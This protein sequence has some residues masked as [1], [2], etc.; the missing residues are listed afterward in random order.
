MHSETCQF[1]LDT[2]KEYQKQKNNDMRFTLFLKAD[3]Q[4]VEHHY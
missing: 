3:R 4:R 1:D 2:V